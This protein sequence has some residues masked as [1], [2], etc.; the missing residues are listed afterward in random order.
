MLGT[1]NFCYIRRKKPVFAVFKLYHRSVIMREKIAQIFR[2][3]EVLSWLLM[4]VF[5]I[6][7]LPLGVAIIHVVAEIPITL[8]SVTADFTLATF[9]V[10]FNIGVY[11]FDEIPSENPPHV[12]AKKVQNRLVEKLIE[13]LVKSSEETNSDKLLEES[14]NRLKKLFQNRLT[15]A[16]LGKRQK[17]LA[18][19]QE[20]EK[21]EFEKR[22]KEDK[23]LRIYSKAVFFCASFCGIIYGI[24]SSNE[25]KLLFLV[26]CILFITILLVFCAYCGAKTYLV[27]QGR[28][29]HERE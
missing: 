12:P 2:N 15:A 26:V 9:S 13:N 14:E 1:K 11:I 10:I 23:R 19:Q 29:R 3:E 4:N 22:H 24:G 7:A 8:S 25:H 21:E 16:S 5:I 20:K 17:R 18:I 27:V 28:K 6:V